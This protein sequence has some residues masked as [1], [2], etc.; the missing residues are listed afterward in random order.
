M[1]IKDINKSYGT[2]NAYLMYMLK[3]DIPKRHNSCL[4]PEILINTGELFQDLPQRQ[5][6]F[7][8]QKWI[9]VHVQ[10]LI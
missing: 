6:T 1:S 2:Q 10:V 4:E 7:K 9:W 5:N 8:L 3:R